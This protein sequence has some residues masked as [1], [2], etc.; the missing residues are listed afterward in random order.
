MIIMHIFTYMHYLLVL[1]V[2]FERLHLVTSFIYSFSAR[3]ICAVNV[4]WPLN[5]PTGSSTALPSS[6]INLSGT[7]SI[8]T[9]SSG[10][11]ISLTCIIAEATSF[12]EM[13][14][15]LSFASFT[16]L[17]CTIVTCSPGIVV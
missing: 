8:S 9:L 4:K 13:P 3:I 10:I 11:S 12:T 5:F 15:S 7:I 16:I 1:Y 2:Q 6:N 17:F 14:A